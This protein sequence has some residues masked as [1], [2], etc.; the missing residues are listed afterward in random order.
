MTR[1]LFRSIFALL[2][3]AS[4]QPREKYDLIIENG[5]VL[6]GTGAA[7]AWV[8]V[9]VRDGR[10]ITLGDLSGAEATQRIDATGLTVSPGFID[11]HAH[12]EPIMRM[13][14]APSH[15]RQGVTTVL[16]GPD[17]G[18]PWPFGKYLDS[19][20][21]H[22]KL[23]MNVAYLTGHN[24]I[25]RRV[26][27]NE[28][29]K[30]TPAELDTM[31]AMVRR[32]MNEGAFGL[33][34]GLKYLP[35]TFSETPEVIALADVAGSMG[36]IYTSHLREEGLGLLQGVREAILI[37]RE[38]HIP[39]VL[40]HHKAMGKPMWGASKTTT[41]L[42]DSARA[43]GLD[44]MMDQYPYTASHTGLSV[45]IPSWALEGTSDDF[46]KRAAD[47]KLKAKMLEGI[48]FNLLNDR[49]GGDLK[50]I[51]F[52]NVSWDSTLQG[53]TL[54]DYVVLQ[55][56]EPNLDNGALATV[57]MQ[58][59]GGAG[60]IFH[61][62]SE[63]D[64]VRIM[65]HPY[66]MHASDGGLA[67]F[68]EDHPHPR[69]Y[70]TFPRIL[71]HYVREMKVL[72]LEEAIRKMTS[73]PARRMNLSDRGVLAVGKVADITLFDAEKVID[74]STFEKPH[75]YPLGI[76]YV[77]VNGVVTVDPKGL[78]G[79]RGGKVLRGTDYLKKRQ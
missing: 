42:V 48:K 49:G 74:K 25:R 37:G 24:T 33:S 17:G 23:T 53:K 3:L 18:G 57:E 39:I 68:G 47:K 38:A 60:C 8:D 78:T 20:T 5:T 1:N 40:T 29:R 79:N 54:Y 12:I 51:Q 71:G 31:K 2:L 76:E 61:A 27:G 36:G 58:L 11:L 72:S 46:K 21:N 69:A 34:T 15:V 30:P 63:E 35:G 28:N 4:C 70:G 52:A 59:K 73:L 10:I 16:G 77:I 75:Q 9:G 62:M 50:N 44:I 67:K 41:G 26:M 55:G 13:P 7:P 14:D 32:A 19:L 22:Y 6:D 43:A 64:V 65:Q 66:T 56:K 45:L